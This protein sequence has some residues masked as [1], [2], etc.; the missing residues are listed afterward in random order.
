MCTSLTQRNQSHIYMCHLQTYTDKFQFTVELIHLS[1]N[2]KRLVG[3]DSSDAGAESA[4]C[5]HLSTLTPAWQSPLEPPSMV[6]AVHAHVP[7]H[8]IVHGYKPR[9][10]SSSSAALILNAIRRDVQAHHQVLDTSTPLRQDC[11]GCQ[12]LPSAQLCQSETT[13][14]LFDIAKYIAE[15]EKDWLAERG[16][17]RSYRCKLVC[18]RKLMSCKAADTDNISNLRLTCMQMIDVPH[19]KSYLYISY[20]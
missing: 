19:T 18:K 17:T 13:A 10:G 5:D 15:Y 1:S 12:S 4:G 11:Q 3:Q 14:M 7:S 6:V 20:I 2:G 9:P 16:N 8:V